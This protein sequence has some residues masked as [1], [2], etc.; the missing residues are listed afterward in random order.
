MHLSWYAPLNFFAAFPN[1]KNLCANQPIG[2]NHANQHKNGGER[3]FLKCPWGGGRVD[4]KYIIFKKVLPP[5]HWCWF[6][7]DTFPF[8]L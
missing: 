7:P 1:K 8:K 4:L 6:A 5:P 3:T 2:A